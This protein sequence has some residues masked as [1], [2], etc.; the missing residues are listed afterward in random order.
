MM[1]ML[2]SVIVRAGAKQDIAI[3]TKPPRKGISALC[4]QP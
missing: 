4:F 2:A 1:A 3:I